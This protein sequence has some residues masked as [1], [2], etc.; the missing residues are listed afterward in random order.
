MEDQAVPAGLVAN[1]LIRASGDN[2]GPALVSGVT[3]QPQRSR[4]PPTLTFS[5]EPLPLRRPELGP[6]LAAFAEG[7]FLGAS[8]DVAGQLGVYDAVLVAADCARAAALELLQ[9][10]DVAGARVVDLG[11]LYS[12]HGASFRLVTCYIGR[13]AAAEPGRPRHLAAEVR[14]PE[15]LLTLDNLFPHCAFPRVEVARVLP[16]NRGV[17]K[18]LAG[19]PDLLGTFDLATL[20]TRSGET[21]YVTR[22]R[23]EAVMDWLRQRGI[24][25]AHG[26][27]HLVIA[28]A[29]A[30]VWDR[31]AF[32]RELSEW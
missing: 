27:S 7:R 22:P 16:E 18:A 24:D 26:D 10:F 9:D 15:V 11:P 2:I 12:R 29:G 5:C 23:S 31:V 1:T 25:P 8:E 20:A 17:A 3:Q 21:L 4:P 19:Q 6:T 14:S 13:L 30:S 28:Q 32:F